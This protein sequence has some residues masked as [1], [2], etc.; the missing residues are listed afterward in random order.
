VKRDA[1]IAIAGAGAVGVNAADSERRAGFG[2]VTKLEGIVPFDISSRS[3]A[4]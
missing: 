3:L 2:R 4:G 1:R